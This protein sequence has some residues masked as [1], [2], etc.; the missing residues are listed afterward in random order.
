MARR[1]VET[2]RKVRF[3]SEGRQVFESTAPF[4][5][6]IGSRVEL[7]GARLEVNDVS[8]V[9]DLVSGAVTTDVQLV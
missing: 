3:F 2:P 4:N 6:A 7:Y 1:T 5:L 9:I 8:E